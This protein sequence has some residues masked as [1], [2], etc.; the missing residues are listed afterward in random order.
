MVG[1]EEREII[2]EQILIKENRIV[3]SGFN[4][5]RDRGY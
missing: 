2:L 4:V 1:R 5:A 3:W